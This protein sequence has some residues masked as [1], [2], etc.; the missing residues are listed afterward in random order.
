MYTGAGMERTP[1]KPS[2]EPLPVTPS[3]T[4]E[5]HRSP[6]DLSEALGEDFDVLR[7]LGTGK[8][9]TVF[10]ARERALSRLVAIKV[11]DPATAHDETTRKRFER[12]AR[13][14]ASLAGHPHVV[15]VYRYGVLPQG[16]PYIIM[17]YVQ[18][19]TME[20]R[21]AAEGRLPVD[22]AVKTLTGVA[23]ALALA[24]SKGI[25]HRDVRPGNVLWDEDS[26]TALLT[27]FGIAALLSTGSADATRLTQSGELLGDP[28]YL[29]PEQ[30]LD[31][32]VTGM[33]DM[34]SFGVTAF[35]ML[36][37][38]PPYQARTPADWVK[39][40]L[41]GEPRDMKQLRWDVPDHV[42][43]LV[44][45]CLS[46]EPKHRPSAADVQ[47]LLEQGSGAAGAGARV[48]AGPGVPDDDVA[49]VQTLLRKRVPQTV[50]ITGGV[51]F[52]ITQLVQG[53]DDPRLYS[54]SL[55][56]AVTA[57][58]VAAVIAWFHGA[59]GRQK[60][61][62]SEYLILAALITLGIALSAWIYLG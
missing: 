43:S 21:L 29:S 48:A 40:H 27:D 24:H 55:V 22:E 8:V 36:T 49:D 39:A 20:E 38:E 23:S 62:P 15:S 47:R 16:D 41:S 14:A 33:S 50:F 4:P 25:V 5:S 35:E 32:S 42:A 51:A 31:E 58:L 26:R 2:T 59:K 54:S 3:S 30:L 34:Y 10:L 46:R 12:E 13:S 18:G 1:R 11:M 61:P 9:A 60:A 17:R 19:R 52:F 57:V 56:L 53:F 7:A 45:R 44:G 37:G 28:R 6:E